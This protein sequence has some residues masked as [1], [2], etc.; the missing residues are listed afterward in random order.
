VPVGAVEAFVVT[1]TLNACPATVTVADRVKGPTP[2][3]RGLSTVVDPE[4]PL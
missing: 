2:A 4:L 1:D 3:E